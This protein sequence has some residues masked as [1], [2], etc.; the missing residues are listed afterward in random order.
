MSKEE[1]IQGLNEDL[2]AELGT[3]IRYNYQASQCVGPAGIELRE[4]FEDE[5]KDE[6]GHARFLSDAVA[7]LGGEPTTAPK[8]FEKPRDVKAML[9]LDVRMEQDD[10][11]NYMRHAAMAEQLGLIELKLKLE[12]IAADEAGHARA[13]QRLVRGM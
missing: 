13:L 11:A 3:I 6:T 4:M 12:E 9:E 5:I 1:L 2:G 7:D 8:S 10:V